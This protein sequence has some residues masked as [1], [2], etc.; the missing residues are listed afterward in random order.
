[1]L[2]VIVLFEMNVETEDVRVYKQDAVGRIGWVEM[3]LCSFFKILNLHF[4]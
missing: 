3:K 1:M 4:I 2:C